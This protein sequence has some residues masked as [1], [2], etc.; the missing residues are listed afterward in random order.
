VSGVADSV[1]FRPVAEND[2]PL[3]YR[4]TSDPTMA[5][6]HEWFGWR[7]P[8][9]FPR[10]WAENGL[11]GDDGGMLIVARGTERLGL[12]S[13]RKIPTGRSSYCWEIGIA[14]APD[15]RG[16]GYGT[17]AQRMLVSYL[18]AHTVANRIQAGTEITNVAEQRALEKAGFTR[19]GVLRGTVFRGGAWRDGIL[20]SI[21]RHEAAQDAASEASGA[22]PAQPDT[23]RLRTGRPARS[24][25]A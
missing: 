2:L 9:E 17:Q 7:D 12:V 20:Y 19:E 3:L 25:K 16:H 13:W 8:R 14:L 23:G 10:Q 11:L 24:R 4:L 18:F 15:A 22:V 1:E 5:G 6:E 21:L